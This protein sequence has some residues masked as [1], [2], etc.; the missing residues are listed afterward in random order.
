MVTLHQLT[1]HRTL[2]YRQR[3]KLQSG[4]KVRQYFCRLQHVFMWGKLNDVTIYWIMFDWIRSQLVYVAASTGQ[5]EK[6]EEEDRCDGDLQ[7]VQ[8]WSHTD[9]SNGHICYL[10][11]DCEVSLASLS[12][13][14]EGRAALCWNYQAGT[15]PTF[16]A[17][18]YTVSI[19]QAPLTCD[20]I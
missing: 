11:Q 2:V 6:E 20:L 19:C 9:S 7:T 17:A 16:T 8:Q 13:P 4:I 18:L 3:M 10:P 5:E 14:P 12:T 15:W 1:S